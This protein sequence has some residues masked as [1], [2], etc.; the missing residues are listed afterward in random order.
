MGCCEVRVPGDVVQIDALL[1]DGKWLT[2]DKKQQWIGGF[3][4]NVD[5]R[6]RQAL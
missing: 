1:P 6:Y 3:H 2:L 5:E 4:S